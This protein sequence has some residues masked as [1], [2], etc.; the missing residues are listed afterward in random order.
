MPGSNLEGVVVVALVVAAAVAVGEVDETNPQ[1]WCPTFQTQAGVR[2]LF[3]QITF[4]A[5]LE[6]GAGLS[7]VITFEG[8]SVKARFLSKKFCPCF[9]HKSSL[10][11]SSSPS[12]TNKCRF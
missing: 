10:L 3:I 5:K 11:L 9:P 6:I 7:G 2:A 1:V 12:T 8:D 4:G